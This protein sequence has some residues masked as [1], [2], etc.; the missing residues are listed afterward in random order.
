VWIG[1]SVENPQTTFAAHGNSANFDFGAL[2]TGGGLYNTLANYSFNR[3]PDF[4]VKMAF[5]PGF[6]HYEIFGILSTF[7]DRV[8]PNA[9]ATTPSSVGAFTDSRTGGGGGVNA[10]WLAA[11]KHVEIGIHALAGDGVGRYGTSSLPDATVRPDGTLSLIH[12]YQGLGT[13]ELHSKKWDVYTYAGG[14]YAARTF[15]LT[16]PTK[17]VGYGAPVFVNSS[18]LI[19]AIPGGGNGFT[20][21]MPASSTCTGDTRN[22]IEGTFG[23]WYKLYNGPKGRIQFGP[24]YSYI[25]RNTWAGA[26]GEPH[27]VENMVLTSFRYYLP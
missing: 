5:E 8:Y 21:G 22:L 17:A 18:C 6:G 14:E 15:Y 26:G 1:A 23:F 25:V 13:I 10:R 24:Q 27:A 3:T 16:S 19:E 20:P 9:T 11:N 4:I 2:G 7:R 12:S